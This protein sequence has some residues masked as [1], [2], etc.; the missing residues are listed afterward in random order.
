MYRL[1]I[2][3][4]WSYSDAYDRLVQLLDSQHLDYYNHSIPRN[5][6]VHTRIGKGRGLLSLLH[7]KRAK[8]KDRGR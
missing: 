1:F 4:S 6:P 7:E 8:G 5:D 2:S 3:H